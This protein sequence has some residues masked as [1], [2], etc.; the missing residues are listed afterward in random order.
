[1]PPYHGNMC[2]CN[3]RGQCE[4]TRAYN[5]NTYNFTKEDVYR[6]EYEEDNKK[7]YEE[8]SVDDILTF[9]ENEKNKDEHKEERLEKVEE[10]IFDQNLHSKFTEKQ[11]MQLKRRNR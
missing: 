10:D 7:Y 3:D 2:S 1:M 6:N 11:G 4:A 9:N 5:K 8:D